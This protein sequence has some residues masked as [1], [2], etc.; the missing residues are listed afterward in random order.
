MTIYFARDLNILS[1]GD[2]SAASLGVETQQTRLIL[3]IVTSLMTA[4]CVSVSGI[5]GFVGLV[6]PHLM[7][8]IIGPDNRML[9]PVSALGGALLLLGADTLTRTALPHEVPIGVLTALIGGPYFCYIFRKRQ[10][11]RM[12]D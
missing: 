3:L 2:K 8:F 12:N 9:L 5:I 1:L 6:V 7:R 4:V 10:L 11:G